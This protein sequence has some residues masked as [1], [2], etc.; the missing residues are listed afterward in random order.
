V[1]TCYKTIKESS[2]LALQ[3]WRQRRKI[4]NHLTP[5]NFISL[6]SDET[7]ILI[8][9]FYNTK[10]NLLVENFEKIISLNP[11]WLSGPISIIE[12]FAKLIYQEEIIY[13]KKNLEYIE[14]MGEFVD[15]KKRSFIENIFNVYTVNNYGTQETWCIAYDCKDK[16]LHL[17]E[18][19]I[20]V[21]IINPDEE[22]YGEIILT[23][24]INYYMPFIKYKIGDLGRMVDSNGMCGNN[25]PIIELKQGR[26]SDFITGKNI[27]GNYF[28]DQVIWDV[29]DKYPNSIFAFSVIQKDID[30][31]SFRIV[32]GINF[33]DE[34]ITTINQRLKSEL[35]RKIETS[36][37]FVEYINYGNTGKLKK[38]ISFIEFRKNKK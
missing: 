19:C 22:G 1:L 15:E 6:F 2:S 11:R 32:K 8:G 35:G 10:K 12:Q 13:E 17:L 37:D 34:I 31:F 25:S 33:N 29:N 20:L 27:L 14:F 26:K 5:E 24:L 21:E 28:F 7:E 9:K 18:N 38:F 30:M 16:H 23:S 3:L 36:F 4:D